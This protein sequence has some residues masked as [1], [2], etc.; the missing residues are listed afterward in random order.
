MSPIR[1]SDELLALAAQLERAGLTGVVICTQAAH[2]I[3]RL[4]SLVVAQKD[5]IDGLQRGGMSSEDATA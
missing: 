2:E 5:E 3:D 4:Q 1:L